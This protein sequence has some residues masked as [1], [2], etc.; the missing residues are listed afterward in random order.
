MTHRLG[1]F[2]EKCEHGIV[3]S[4]CRCPGPKLIR[5][6]PCVHKD[7]PPPDPATRANWAQIMLIRAL[8]DGRLD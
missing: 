1:H 5:R 4:Q 7:L 3:L 6:V 8:G 2:M